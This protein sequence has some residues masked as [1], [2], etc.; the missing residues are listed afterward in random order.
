MSA[1]SLDRLAASIGR[2]GVMQPI[3]V[4]PKPDGELGYEIVAG[5]RRWRA[6]QSLGMERIPAV[7]RDI[8]DEQAA[9][10]ALM[11]NVHRE[12]LNAIE[13]AQALESMGRRFGLTQREVAQRVGLERSSVANLL[14][15]LYLEE[16]VRE[17]IAAGAL[18]AGHGKVLAAMPG[19]EDRVSL[20]RRAQRQGWSVRRL[21]REFTVRSRDDQPSAGH[22]QQSPRRAIQ[23][24]VERRLGEALGTKVRITTGAAG[25]KGRLVLEFYSLEHFDDLISRLG[26]SRCLEEEP[27]G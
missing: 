13:R 12:D 4:R 7:V 26:V 2:A 25:K 5:E 6:C 19:G 1:E 15:L 23:G 24:D 8:D 10:W 20:A 11:E 17:M 22:A 9:Q 21:E 16:P 14:R 27:V 18:S 3:V